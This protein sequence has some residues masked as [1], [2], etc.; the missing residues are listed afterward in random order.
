M[1][2]CGLLVLVSDKFIGF[3]LDS[4][5]IGKIVIVFN[6]HWQKNQHTINYT[7]T[8]IKL[9]ETESIECYSKNNNN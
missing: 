6:V 4:E 1:N 7:T 5:N 3:V 2:V 9:M 8:C